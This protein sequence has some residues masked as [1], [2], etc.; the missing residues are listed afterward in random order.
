MGIIEKLAVF[1][2]Q[3]EDIDVINGDGLA[4]DIIDFIDA[5]VES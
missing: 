1:L 3:R 2:E 5:N 4:A